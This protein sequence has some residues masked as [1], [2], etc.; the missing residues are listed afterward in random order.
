[1]RKGGDCQARIR[2]SKRGPLIWFPEG[3]EVIEAGKCAGENC[4]TPLYLL[5]KNNLKEKGGIGRG[6]GNTESCFFQ[7]PEKKKKKEKKKK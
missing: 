6:R 2:V 3:G 1:V 7:N 5:G 4:K